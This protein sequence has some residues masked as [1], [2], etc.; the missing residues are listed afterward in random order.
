MNTTRLKFAASV[1]SLAT[2][3]LL[4]LAAPTGPTEA[5]QRPPMPCVAIRAGIYPVGAGFCPATASAID[6]HKTARRLRA[7]GSDVA[8]STDTHLTASPT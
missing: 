4:L 5:W 2:S 7:A 3:S 8:A 1:G 6:R